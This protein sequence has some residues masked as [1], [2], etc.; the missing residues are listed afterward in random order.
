LYIEDRAARIYA[1]LAAEF[2]RDDSFYEFFKNLSNDEVMHYH[3]MNSALACLQ[4]QPE[5]VAEIVLDQRTK[6][7]V[8]TPLKR[9]EAA[10]QSGKINKALIIESV[11]ESEQSE[12]NDIF[13]YVINSLK[14]FY[15]RFNVIG[16]SIQNHLRK[17]EAFIETR[18]DTAMYLPA[19]RKLAPVWKEKVLVVDDYAP[20]VEVLSSFLGKDGGV[21]TA[22]NGQEALEKAYQ[23]YYSVIISD[24]DMP[25]MD[26]IEF[27]KKLKKDHPDVGS[28]F[29]FM[30]GSLARDTAEY[31]KKEN[32]QYMPKPVHLLDMRQVVH[33]VIDKNTL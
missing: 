29:I 1:E 23:N 22:A 12:W 30:S 17:I 4:A 21:E 19:F 14:D 10:V 15:P 11:I 32:L 27:Y 25:I 9:I 33:A 24:I 8:E 28:R 2:D 20:V 31:L 3:F 7:N 26:G 16:P 5:V 6:E 13:L 18:P